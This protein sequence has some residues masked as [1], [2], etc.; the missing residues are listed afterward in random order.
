MKT[1]SISKF[2]KSTLVVLILLMSALLSFAQNTVVNGVVTDAK[3]KETL[4]Y[5][6]V[7][8][9]G[10]TQGTNSDNQ[11]KFHLVG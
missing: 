9:V 8:F 10:T 5:V 3:S 4:P 6:T 1:I 2:Y 7:T 11:G